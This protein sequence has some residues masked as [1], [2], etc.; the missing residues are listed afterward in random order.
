MASLRTT[1]S[2]TGAQAYDHWFEQR[3]ST[4][5]ADFGV[6]VGVPPDRPL[7]LYLCSSPFITPYEV[8]FVRRW[9]EAVRHAP[10][11]R[12]ATRGDSDSSASAERRAVGGLRSVGVRGGR[13]LAARRREPGRQRRA[14]RLLRLDVP[15]RRHGR[16]QHQR[17]DRI[18]HRRSSGVHGAGVA[19]S[20]GSRK[21][22]CTSS[23]SRTP[24]AGCCTWPRRWRSISRS[25]RRVVRGEHDAAKS[26][27]FVEAFVRPH[28][29]DTPAAG[30][31]VEVIEATAA[32][33]RPA[34]VGASL[35]SATDSAVPD[36]AGGAGALARRSARKA[37]R[38]DAR[39]DRDA[40]AA[41][42][43]RAGRRPST[44]ATTTRR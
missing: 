15:Q 42:A 31:F 3:P 40:A 32:A 19:S 35:L 29:L 10:D 26:R 13:H 12:A 44:S 43:V 2:V 17:A 30:K 33:P 21:A 28:G 22:R 24:T 16:H 36:A 9:I 5:R 18:G 20:P 1:V 14:R 38:R 11:P 27:A 41:A 8:G 4:T 6:K 34:P 25:W 23:T 7:L 39:D 37:R